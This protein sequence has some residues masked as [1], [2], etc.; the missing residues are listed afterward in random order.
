MKLIEWFK[1]NPKMAFFLLIGVMIIVLFLVARSCVNKQQYQQIVSNAVL[2]ERNIHLEQENAVLNKDVIVLHKSNDSLYTQLYASND[3]L[4]AEVKKRLL[5]EKEN[6]IYKNKVKQLNDSSAVRM[7]LDNANLDYPV[8]RYGEPKDSVYLSPILAIRKANEN[9]VD[10]MEFKSINS[11]LLNE[12]KI[13]SEYSRTL[14]KIIDNKDSEIATKDEIIENDL[15]IKTN[16]QEQIKNDK[17]VLRSQKVKT[18]VVGGIGLVLTGLA[19]V[20]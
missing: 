11:Y 17:K 16:Y 2:I 6:A 5:T 3:I 18:I 13:Q 20:F 7:F 4:V 14:G 1:S 19:I 8:L 9:Q 10:L 15:K 12:N